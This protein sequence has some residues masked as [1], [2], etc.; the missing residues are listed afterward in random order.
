MQFSSVDEIEAFRVNEGNSLLHC[1]DLEKVALCVVFKFLSE[2]HCELFVPP[3]SGR[4][5]ALPTLLLPIFNPYLAPC[6]FCVAVL[7]V[8]CFNFDSCLF[9]FC[10]F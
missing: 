7:Q 4:F 5:S 6:Q 2:I 8:F 10:L 3:A 9:L 1:A